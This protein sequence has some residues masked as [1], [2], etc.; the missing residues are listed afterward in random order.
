M[1]LAWVFFDRAESLGTGYGPPLAR[2]MALL[3]T[4]DDALE[5][6]WDQSNETP[7]AE[8]FRATWMVAAL[9]YG[10]EADLRD[11]FVALGFPIDDP[12]YEK[13]YA[14]LP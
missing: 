2:T 5:A 14:R 8:T 9:S 12:L 10:F 11:D 3:Q 1:I 4:F 6:S 13:L 7:E